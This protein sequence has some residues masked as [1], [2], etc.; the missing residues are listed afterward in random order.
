MP[1]SQSTSR[2]HRASNGP[3]CVKTYVEV[4]HIQLVNWANRRNALTNI[5]IVEFTAFDELEAMAGIK[6]IRS[7]FFESANFNRERSCIRLF[8][9]LSENSRAYS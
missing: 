6:A 9:N 5:I 8:E 7:A 2:G 1:V 3:E 4:H